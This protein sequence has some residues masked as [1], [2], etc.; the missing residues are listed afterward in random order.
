MASVSFEQAT[1]RYPGA[2]RPALDN[3]D[4]VVGD[5]EFVV[6]VGP[7]GCGKTTSLRM[8][9]G[10]E[11]V[12]SGRIRIGDRDVTH[13]DPKN[14][15]VAMV[16]QNYALYPH[17]TVAENMGFAMKIAKIPKAQIR[18]RVLDAAKLLDLQPYLDRKPKDLSG[19]QRQRV[20]MGRAIVRRPQVFL[21]DEPL[22]NL[23]A[24]LRVQTRNQIAA[25]Q[26]RLGTTTVYVT[27]DQVEAM[28]MGDRVAVLCDGVLQQFA[29]P[30]EL[31]RNP[32]NVFVAGF[33]G[34][35]A[36]NLFTLPVADSAMALGDWS[37]PVPR[38][39]A[40][41]AGEVVVGVRPEHFEL[42]GH[43]VEMEVDVV[44]ELGADAYLYG[45]ITGS[46]KVIDAPIVARADGRNPPARGSRVR[47]HPQPGH[48]HFFGVDGRRLC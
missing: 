12:D 46:G 17:M 4:L 43:G 36:M 32:A 19:G 41:A 7:S 2:D 37:V 47:L 8:V 11:T 1:R 39:I 44:E 35:P 9:A 5:G 29:P 18:E 21:M 25:L 23:D 38:E 22:S 10:L 30:R 42:G 28:T 24:K 45:R 48:L 26:R 31:Y 13:V 15:D 33:I 14:R 40:G 34:S 16:F 6:L 20:A 3:L 27:H